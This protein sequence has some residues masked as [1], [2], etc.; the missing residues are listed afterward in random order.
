MMAIVQK[1]I[2]RMLAYSSMENMGIIGIGVGIGVL[3]VASGNNILSLL[4][5]SGGVLHVLNHSLFKSLLF[6]NAGSVYQATHT[7]NTEQLGWLMKKMPYT[8]GLFLTGSLAIC[9]LPPFNGFISQ[10][11]I[12]IGMFKSLSTAT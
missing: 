2:K 6:F 10:Y 4:G 11:L 9:G 7:R 3:G 1:D 5:F 12:Y 8:A